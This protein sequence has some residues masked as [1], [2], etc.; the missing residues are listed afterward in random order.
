MIL[1][2]LTAGLEEPFSELTRSLRPP[3]SPYGFTVL[4]AFLCVIVLRTGIWVMNLLLATLYF[5]QTEI[6][7]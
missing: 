5:M 2:A 7:L 3:R 1:G 6:Y 4:L